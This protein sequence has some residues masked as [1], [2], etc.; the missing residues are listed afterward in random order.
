M[1]WKHKCYDESTCKMLCWDFRVVIISQPEAHLRAC[2]LLQTLMPTDT[3]AI[4]LKNFLIYGGSSMRPI[5]MHIMW[6]ALSWKLRRMVN[7]GR[8][9]PQPALNSAKS[10]ASYDQLFSMRANRQNMF[11]ASLPE[12][13]GSTPKAT[14]HQFLT[15]TEQE[16][17]G[18][19]PSNSE[20]AQRSMQIGSSNQLTISQTWNSWLNSAEERNES[21]GSWGCPRTDG[22]FAVF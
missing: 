4:S 11:Q 22:E 17:S 3:G 5:L 15:K 2:S 19:W 6:W 14:W 13:R 1:R 7:D 8:R 10:G 18:V 21:T 9:C 12:R 20:S 16:T